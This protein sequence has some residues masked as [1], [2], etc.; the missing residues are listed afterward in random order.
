LFSYKYTEIA[1]QIKLLQ[2]FLNKK[3]FFINEKKGVFNKNKPFIEEKELQNLKLIGKA[4][5][6]SFYDNEAI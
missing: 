2:F 4:Q 5:N 6:L 1:I 3:Y